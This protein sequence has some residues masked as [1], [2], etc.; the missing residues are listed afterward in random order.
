[1]GQFL[2]QSSRVQAV[3]DMY[4]ISDLTQNYIVGGDGGLSRME[5]GVADKSLAVFKAAS[6]VTYISPDDPPF[7]IL[8]GDKDAVVPIT[9]SQILQDDLIAGGVKSTFVTVH[10]GGHGFGAIGGPISPTYRE[11]YQ[12][13]DGFFDQYLR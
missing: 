10:N 5:F 1:V 7:L 9:Q 4:G 6:P 8:H 3:V 12:L 2:D 13:I 11:I